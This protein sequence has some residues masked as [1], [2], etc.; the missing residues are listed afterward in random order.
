[1]PLSDKEQQILQEIEKQLI[2]EDPKF[3]RGVATSLAGETSRKVKIGIVVFGLG[4]AGL[5]AFFFTQSVFIGAAAFLVMLAG[6][7]FSYH[8]A[9]RGAVEMA[10]V[11]QVSPLQKLFGSARGSQSDG[12]PDEPNQRN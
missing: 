10:N 5:V 6:A 12:K 2:T 1:M 7:T 8:H 11:K 3:A 9:R 4:F